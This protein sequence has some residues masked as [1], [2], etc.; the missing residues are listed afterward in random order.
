[1]EKQQ[2]ILY[3]DF[4]QTQKW[5]EEPYEVEFKGDKARV[6]SN[7]FLSKGKAS[8]FN[9]LSRNG[10]TCSGF[11]YGLTVNGLKVH[12]ISKYDSLKK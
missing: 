2:I 1:M 3:K 4:D 9:K 7:H 12:F 11:H 6:I 5:N 10:Q 8:R